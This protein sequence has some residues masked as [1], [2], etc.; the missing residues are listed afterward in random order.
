MDSLPL[1]F[2][3]RDQGKWPLAHLVLDVSHEGHEVLVPQL[4]LKSMLLTKVD[5]LYLK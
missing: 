1:V 3:L 2:F 4:F 5:E